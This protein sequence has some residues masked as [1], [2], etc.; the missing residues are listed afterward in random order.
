[1]AV[2]QFRVDEQM[3]PWSFG[4]GCVS[5]CLWFLLTRSESGSGGG[6]NTLLRRESTLGHEGATSLALVELFIFLYKYSE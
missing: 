5:C 4:W 6:A 2:T 3:I 1:M